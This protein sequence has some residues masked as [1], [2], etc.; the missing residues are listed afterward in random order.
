MGGEAMA[1]ASRPSEGGRR[2][3]RRRLL[4]W[5]A[6]RLGPADTA[7]ALKEAEQQAQRAEKRLREAIDVLP[8]GLVFLDP[9]GRYLLWNEKYAEIYHRS[10]DLFREGVKLADTL[11]VGVARGDYPEA[12]G[13]RGGLAGRA[14]GAARQPRPAPPAAS[15]RRSLGDDRRAPHQR[16]RHHRAARRHH[17]DE[18]A[19]RG[20]QAGARPRRGGQ[21]R[22]ERLRRQHEPRDQDAAERRAGAGRGAGAQR[23]RRA[24]A[25]DARARSSPPRARS[26]ASSPISWIS[27]GSKR[28]ALSSTRRPSIW[29][30]SSSRL[31]RR[32]P[33]RPRPKGWAS[34]PRSRTGPPARSRAIRF[35]CGRS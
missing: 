13:S 20:A 14:H 8:E 21:P 31:R 2:S 23:S 35:G 18:G 16:R 3:W 7:S 34:S 1:G 11:K 6:D 22:Q 5:L 17:R 30:I 32:S 33:R 19:G 25:R 15:G 9:E 29:P 10:A 24:S 4:G 27:A 28:G 12:V 26:T